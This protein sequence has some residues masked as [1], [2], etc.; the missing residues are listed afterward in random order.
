MQV[1]YDLDPI[2]AAIL[3]QFISHRQVRPVVTKTGHRARGVYPAKRA[4]GKARYESLNEQR[5]WQ[6]VDCSNRILTFVTHPFVLALPDGPK[7]IHYTPDAIFLDRVKGLVIFE[8]KAEYFLS[9]EDVRRDLIKKAQ[10]L[11]QCGLRFAVGLDSDHAALHELLDDIQA[12]RP[13][14]RI[15][16]GAEK[17][18]WDP[19]AGTPPPPELCDAWERAKGLC[20][21][22]L[23]RAMDRGADPAL[24][25]AN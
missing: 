19:A 12:V 21:Q 5:F 3:N 6:A 10:I 1:I 4:T 24:I 13:V 7:K 25:V 8:A 16:E 20:D 14:G 18:Q 22:L 17:T 2:A 9:K 11:K 23:Q 15:P